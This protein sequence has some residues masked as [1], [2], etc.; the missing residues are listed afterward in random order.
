MSLITLVLFLISS[1]VIIDP[2][3]FYFSFYNIERKDREIFINFC[4][5]V[6]SNPLRN[7]SFF[8]WPFQCCMERFLHCIFKLETKYGSKPIYFSLNI[9]FTNSVWH[10]LWLSDFKLTFIRLCTRLESRSC[11]IPK[12]KRLV[13]QFGRTRMFY[14]STYSYYAIHFFVKWYRYL[15]VFNQVR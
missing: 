9:V 2:I 5:C 7:N 13:Y 12:G 11:C 14:A 6:A 15:N 4:S 1:D 3:F 8:L 10:F